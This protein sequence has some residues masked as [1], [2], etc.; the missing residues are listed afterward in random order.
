MKFVPAG[1]LRP[2]LALGVLALLGALL[3]RSVE[4]RT[5]MADFLPPAETPEAAF[6][7]AELR[8][9]AATTLL[10]AGIEGAEE[11]ELAR[12]SRTMG[13]ALRATG[14]F[15]FV[16]NGTADLTEPEQAL[17]FR[18]RYLLGNS[19]GAFAEPALR[20]GLEG[21]LDGLRSS[22]S[23]V[24]ARLG[25]ADPTGLFLETIKGWLGGS[26][27][28]VRH[29]AWF[30]GEGPPRALMVARSKALGTDTEAQR[31]AVEA[32]R[33]AF[34][35]AGPGE[36]RLLL[37]GP[38][39][40]AASAAAA[41]RADVER[42]AIL[43]AVLLL[44]FLVWRY[45]SATLLLVVGVPLLAG[46][47]AGALA[48]ALVFGRLQGAALGFGVTMLGVAVD[49]PILLLTGRRPGEAMADAA[50]RIWPT[51]RLAAGAAALGLVAMM[52][53]G[54][55]GLAQLGLFGAAGLLAGAGVT[56]WGLPWLAPDAVPARPLPGAVMRGLQGASGRPVL[57]AALV[58][59]ALVWLALAGPPRWEDDMARL[60]PVP[61]ADQELDT[62]L[63]AQLG[64]P[65][66][67]HLVALRGASE[68]AVL[69]ASERVAGALAP[70]LADGRLGGL[71]LPS[72]YLP[73]RATQAARQAGMPERTV[74]EAR[75]AGAM[76]GLP[77]RPGAFAPFLDAVEESRGL[78][79][80]DTAAMAVAPLIS[81]RLSPLLSRRGDGWVGMGLLS[82]VQDAGAV[83]AAVAGLAD[84]GVL[85]VDVKGETE[86]MIA[87]TTAEALIWCG[88]G[89]LG[90]LALLGLGLRG[91]GAAL[92]R[93]AP[94]AGAVL[95][96]L[97]VL[98]ALGE[99]LTPFHLVALLLMAGVGLDYALFLGAATRDPE[100]AARTAG[101]V[102]TCTVTTLL[103]FGMLAL[104]ETPVLRGI[105]ITVSAGVAAAFILALLLAPRAGARA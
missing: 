64:A 44:G 11:A 26:S 93:A 2:L 45:R 22:L 67:R 29:G 82:G 13:E 79:L 5:D 8:E 70:L 47:L 71:E 55:P 36:A 40:F 61:K 3:F 92:L 69:R 76:R 20:K 105:G 103:T 52:A 19:E 100:E 65:D 42:M 57:A 6:L 24:L 68:E 73:S 51:L 38:G 56:R 75:L 17:L 14:R 18:Y 10:L 28:Q 4:I 84:P 97:A 53:S 16:G 21:L 80:L 66:V 104:C 9:G 54:F 89:A 7:L 37:S 101:A 43:S 50:R 85:F 35:G 23:G 72:R 83:R 96:V 12:I 34:E 49:Y 74:L 99:R 88:V 94:I 63:R 59:L 30:A 25:F 62:L 15:A 31:E 90:V 41:V 48:V 77:F 98:S 87:D 1:M 78:P 91:G 39:V 60:S 81:T 46:T 58:A 95:V 33:T 102:M 32:V 27:V 86:A